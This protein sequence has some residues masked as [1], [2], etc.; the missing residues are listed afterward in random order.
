VK[1]CKLSRLNTLIDDYFNVPQERTLMLDRA[2]IGLYSA[3]CFLKEET[4]RSKVLFTSNTCPSPVFAC[5]YAG[6]TPVFAD[7]SLDDYLMDEMDSIQKIKD[8]KNDLAAVV[9]IYTYGHTSDNILSIQRYSQKYGIALIEDVAQA[10]GS[11]VNGELTG[12]IGDLSVFSF[13]YSKHIDAGSGGF[14][15]SNNTHLFDLNKIENIISSL[16]KAKDD[17]V[18]AKAYSEEFYRLRHKAMEDPDMFSCYSIFVSKYKSLYFKE[19]S[20]NWSAITNKFQR[21][22]LNDLQYQRNETA[23][24][25]FN[26][27]FERGLQSKIYAPK[28]KDGYSIYRY[29]ILAENLITAQELSECLRTN[30]IHCSNLYIPVSRFFENRNYD[31]ALEFSKRCINLWVDDLADNNYINKS[32]NCIDKFYKNQ[33]S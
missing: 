30:E 21:F 25:Y 20:P 15:I 17:A 32:L 19:L 27:I 14:M 26:G 12:T 11:K 2:F 7:I 4:G 24:K 18:L 16:S 5:V 8:N 22:I 29:T 9:Y 31:K 10:L 33:K 28:V 6:M 1:F 3:F 23:N 13:G